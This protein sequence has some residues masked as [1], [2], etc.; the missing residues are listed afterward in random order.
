MKEMLNDTYKVLKKDPTEEKKNKL[1]ALL[2]PLLKDNKINKQ[3]YNHPIHTANITPRI[4]G[5]PKIHKPGTP[6][7]PI[8][9]S[10]GSVTYNLSKAIAEI[11]KPML[12]QTEQHCKNLKELA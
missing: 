6:L 7:R 8:V 12:R 3:T 4:Y 10:I 11:I 5:T 1:K 2:K 9:N